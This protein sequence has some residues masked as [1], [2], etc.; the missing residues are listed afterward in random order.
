MDYK[1]IHEMINPAVRPRTPTPLSNALAR[2]N[3][4]GQIEIGGDIGYKDLIAA[5]A[6]DP[7]ARTTGYLTAGAT[8]G[9]GDLIAA[10]ETYNSASKPLVTGANEM[11]VTMESP[12]AKGAE[13][14]LNAL[15][16][17]PFIPA[18]GGMVKAAK[19]LPEAKLAQQAD[20]LPMD[21]AV[22]N[23]I[24]FFTTAEGEGHRLPN[25]V[26]AGIIPES[27]LPPQA[28]QKTVTIY[29]AVRDDIKDA[30]IRE[31]DWV[32]L[33]KDYAAQHGTG[34]TGKSKVISM[35]V[36]AESIGWAGTDM[37]EYFYVPK[38]QADSLPTQH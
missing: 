2:R 27:Y 5:L 3:I 23:R 30:T 28:K 12:G 7:M 31:G 26:K 8:P 29:R 35:E 14:A 6:R 36:P 38:K 24:D 22:K 1:S 4:A 37:N 32:S 16:I 20:S 11:G 13:I 33:D 9:A 18:M 10:L 21:E 17:L 34:P 19:G 25:L 15:G